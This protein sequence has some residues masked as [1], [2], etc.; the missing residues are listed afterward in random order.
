MS[1][2]FEGPEPI[3]GLPS[4]LPEGETILWSG[5][6]D[7]TVVA[8][9]VF[10]TRIVTGYFIALGIWR[11]LSKYGAAPIEEAIAYGCAV[12]PVYIVA[13][14]LLGLLAWMTARTTVY[15]VTNRRV[16]MRFGIALP[17]TINVPFA[18]IESASVKLYPN[19]SGDIPLA[20]STRDTFT[21]VMLWPHVRP[22]RFSRPEP[23]L[24]CLG[25]A[26]PV[27][28]LLSKAMAAFHGHAAQAAPVRAPDS[29]TMRTRNDDT[30]GLDGAHPA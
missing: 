13:M 22:R 3:K 1:D 21:Y 30:S 9:R 25:D 12:I 16:A 26:Q 5:A 10:Y 15:T 2:D 6:P 11:F 29:T 14:A 23:M 19:G 27:A 28:A 18:Q 17:M 4:Q 20:L 24:R 8:R 7:W